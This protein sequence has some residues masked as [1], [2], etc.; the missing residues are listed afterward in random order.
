MQKVAAGHE[1]DVNVRL[2][3]TWWPIAHWPAEYV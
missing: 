1:M 3:W 2:C